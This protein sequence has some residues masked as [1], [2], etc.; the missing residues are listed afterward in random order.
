MGWGL[1]LNPFPCFR[2]PPV[3]N[4]FPNIRSA[5]PIRSFNRRHVSRERLAVDESAVH[6]IDFHL[7]ILQGRAYI[8]HIAAWVGIGSGYRKAM[9]MCLNYIQ[10]IL[11]RD[12]VNTIV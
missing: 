8:E 10:E 11:R 6:V 2:F 3:G 4:D 7:G 5:C 1:F 12:S 9:R